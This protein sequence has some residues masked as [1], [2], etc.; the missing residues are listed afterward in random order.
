MSL[1][2]LRMKRRSTRLQVMRED[3]FSLSTFCYSEKWSLRSEALMSAVLRRVANT[4]SHRII[5]CD[6]NMD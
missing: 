3:T 4:A 6:V 2:A 5:A 1:L